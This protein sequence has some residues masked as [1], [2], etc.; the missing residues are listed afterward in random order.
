MTDQRVV[1]SPPEGIEGWNEVWREDLQFPHQESTGFL[2]SLF[3]PIFRKLFYS[4]AREHHDRQRNFNMAVL[5]LAEGLR[6][7]VGSLRNDLAEL[8]KEVARVRDLIPIAV[9]RN[10]ALFSAIDQKIETVSSRL[11][12]LTNQTAEVSRVPPERKADIVYRRLEDALRGSQAEITGSLR[13][14]LPYIRL[15]APVVDLG[16][17]RGEF[18]SLCKAEGIDAQGFDSNERSVADLQKA[19]LKA[20]LGRVPDCLD[21]LEAGSVGTL[22]ASHLVEH[23]L[24]PD[25]FAL[26]AGGYRVLRSGGFLIIETPNA[27]SI[28]MSS[29]DFWRDPTHLAPRHIASLSV[30]SRE[31]GFDVEDFRTMH[32]FS[33]SSH[34]KT[35]ASDPPSLQALSHELNQLIFGDQDLRLVLRKP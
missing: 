28:R 34:F 10:D 3:F 18:L 5:E 30:L 32:P 1:S 4:A 19:G 21:D 17:G 25:L 7:D 2:K 23:I 26:F 8:S 16:C 9:R 15:Q 12:D 13:D 6:T 11:R 33:L 20:E 14:Y 22:F 24:S 31:H 35:E 29:S 27:E